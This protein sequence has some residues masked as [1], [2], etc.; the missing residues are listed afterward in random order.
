MC[1]SPSALIVQLSEVLLAAATGRQVSVN[2]S[3][4][5]HEKQ[6]QRRDGRRARRRSLV[7]WRTVEGPDRAVHGEATARDEERVC[8]QDRQRRSTGQQVSL[9]PDLP[10]LMIL[11]HPL[12]LSFARLSHSPARRQAPPATPCLL[13]SPFLA[14]V[15]SVVCM[16]RQLVS[17]LRN[18][19]RFRR[20]SLSARERVGEM[21]E[22]AHE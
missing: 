14:S 20:E 2:G 13:D 6:F 10:I 21:D 22:G 11:M 18:I 8:G 15:C 16:R 9:A 12:V 7:R 1:I 5:Q 4:P 3:P 19:V 17:S